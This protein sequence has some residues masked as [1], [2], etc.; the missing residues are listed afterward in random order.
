MTVIATSKGKSFSFFKKIPVRHS[1][2]SSLSLS[3]SE[4]LVREGALVPSSHPVHSDVARQG[5]REDLVAAAGIQASNMSALLAA[6]G[7]RGQRPTK[8]EAAA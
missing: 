7:L 6:L 1:L 5:R 4:A 3:L 8:G 2:S